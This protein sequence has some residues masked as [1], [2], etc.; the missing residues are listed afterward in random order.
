MTSSQWIH[1]L[2]YIIAIV[3]FSSI[4]TRSVAELILLLTL[5][6]YNKVNGWKRRD[7]E[8][9]TMAGSEHLKE[10]AKELGLGYNPHDGTSAW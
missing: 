5:L 1:D 9:V 6:L 3:F 10:T 7:F 4:E 2:K 8:Q